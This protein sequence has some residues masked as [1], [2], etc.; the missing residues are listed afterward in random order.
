MKRVSKGRLILNAR[1][2]SAVCSWLGDQESDWLCEAKLGLCSITKHGPRDFI[3]KRRFEQALGSPGAIR[4]AVREPAPRL[5]LYQII[6]CCSA[7]QT[8]NKK[9]LVHFHK[10]ADLRIAPKGF[11]LVES[12]CGLANGGVRG[13]RQSHH[14]LALGSGFRLLNAIWAN[15]S[16]REHARLAMRADFTYQRVPLF[17]QSPVSWN[18]HRLL[19][20]PSSIYSIRPTFTTG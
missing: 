8:D 17:L 12:A 18:F 10:H 20:Y 3:I 1:C 13:L 2:S 6:E 15:F 9:P 19:L 4:H 5:I 16:G 7:A 14:G 11:R